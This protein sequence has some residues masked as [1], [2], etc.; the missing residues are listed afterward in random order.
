MT[1]TP[2]VEITNLDLYYGK[3]K[4]LDDISTSFTSGSCVV[5]C[6]PSGSGKSSLL[7][8]INRLED[9]TGVTFCLM[10]SACATPATSR[11]SVPILE[12]YFSTLNFTHIST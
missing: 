3:H 11:L 1:K 2:I 8:C 4:A 6:G 9:F 12:W 10:V 5:I 7:R